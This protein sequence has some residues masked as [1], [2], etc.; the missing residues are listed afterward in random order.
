MIE[1]S[2]LHYTVGGQAHEL[3][4]GPGISREYGLA[5]LISHNGRDSYLDLEDDYRAVPGDRVVYARVAE[6]YGADKG[7]LVQYWFFYL[8]NATG[9]RPTDHEGDWEGIQLW[10]AGLGRDDLLNAAVPTQLGYAAHES[11][12]VLTPSTNCRSVDD[13]FRPNVYVARNR[14]ASYPEPGSGGALD[15]SFDGRDQFQGNGA[16]WTLPGR[17]VP[18]AEGDTEEYEIRI[19]PSVHQSWLTWQGKWGDKSGNDGPR[20]PAFKLHFWAPPAFNGWSGG[21]V[22]SCPSASE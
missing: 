4:P 9:A 12:W 3:A 14:H 10:F 19:M 8:Y 5:D 7:V 16:V 21:R 11:G 18:D 2:T 1:L 13:P 22:F 17:D 15:K 20:G 6:L